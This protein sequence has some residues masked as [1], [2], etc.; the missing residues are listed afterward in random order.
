MKKIIPILLILSIFSFQKTEAQ[1][2]KLFKYPFVNQTEFGV[3]FGRNKE[4]YYYYPYYSSVY[5][6]PSSN[7]FNIQNVASLSLQTF[8]GFQVRK[9]TSIGITTGLDAYNSVLIVPIAAGF[10]H[11]LFEKN[12]KG[13]KLQTGLDAGF[14]IANNANSNENAKGGILLNPAVGFKFPTK[15]GSSWLVNFGYKYQFIEI[16]QNYSDDYNISTV[17][18][19]NLKRFSVKVG[20]EF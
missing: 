1:T 15:N 4:T 20:F 19:R 8:N 3:L 13:A 2:K 16:T 14:G 11:V 12:E 7:G 17:E 18:T 10:R 5:Y 6:P 9:K